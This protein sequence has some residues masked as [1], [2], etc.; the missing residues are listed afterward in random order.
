M[1][2]NALQQKPGK[3]GEILLLELMTELEEVRGFVYR[4]VHAADVSLRPKNISRRMR[5]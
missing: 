1:L 5:N 3:E 4:M 2:Q